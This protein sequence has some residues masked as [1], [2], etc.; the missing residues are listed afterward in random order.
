M[1]EKKLINNY[2]Y[3]T[4]SLVIYLMYLEKYS[5]EKNKE[6]NLKKYNPGHLGTSLSINFLLA[7]LYYFLNKY[8]IKSQPIIGTG[9][10][11]ASLISN[12]W[13][14]GTLK[15]YY[16]EYSSDIEG[17]NNLINDFGTKL[18]SEINPQYPET[19]YDGGELGYS[20]GVAYGYALDS[21]ALLVP[22]IIG[23]G[24]AETG[25][26][27]SS[28]QLNKILKTK[29]KVLPIIN[30][31][32]LKMGSKSYLSLLTNDE[33]IGLFSSF[34]YNVNIVDC[35]DDDDILCGIE[36]MQNCLKKSINQESPL[37][38]F[39]SHKGFTLPN[40]E[41]VNFRDLIEVH[42]NPLKKYD[43]LKKSKIVSIFLNNWQTEIFDSTGKVL[44][45]FDKFRPPYNE[46]ITKKIE[47]TD[48]IYNKHIG[49][50][51]NL[52][53]YLFLKLSKNNGIIFSPDELR[54]NMLGNLKNNSIEILNENLLQA[55]YQGYINAGNNGVYIAYEGFMSIISS[56]VAQYYKYLQQ[57]KDSI[58]QIPRNSLNYILTSTAWENCF[59]HQNPNFVDDL[60][61]KNDSHYNIFYPKDSKELIK[62]LEYAFSTH[63]MINIITSSKR[64]NIEYCEY[65][66]S[67]NYIDVLVEDN[68]PDIVLCAT[69]D[70]MLDYAFQIYE[71]LKDKYRIKLIYVTNP[72][73]L[74][75]NSEHALSENI[76]K[77]YFPDN[78]PI[79]YFFMGYPS[80][81]KALLYDRNVDCKII[82][83][84]DGLSIT[85]RL[86]ETLEKNNFN[87]EDIIEYCE[88]KMVKKLGRCSIK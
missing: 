6:T 23:D 85:G 1:S 22:C 79:I 47:L 74:D 69:G 50:V 60:L 51:R 36:K 27:S 12:L 68:S 43:D 31:N 29:S 62:I 65:E 87:S 44:P 77:N 11:A 57:K 14:N 9:H 17:L 86:G 88:K 3:A 81:I 48:Y 16:N 64:H 76:F 80:I 63:D 54:S 30:L 26:I 49:N 59:S 53:Q 61:I 45:L 55:L 4:N 33:L 40:I 20:L 66:I 19:I 28:W 82:G 24:E 71:K 37:I 42:K 67:D 38:I 73:I 18:R 5:I 41:N 39:K 34:G 70:Y 83:Y 52:E 35:M 46:C 72:K 7:N 10:S 84:K 56:M 75:V 2:F 21:A 78:K 13:L 32:G 25:T 8:N 58:N 15:K